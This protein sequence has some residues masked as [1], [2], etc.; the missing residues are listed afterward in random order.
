MKIIL[1]FL[2]IIATTANAQRLTAPDYEIGE[3]IIGLY[4]RQS[5]ADS[6]CIIHRQ[7]LF[8]LNKKDKLPTKGCNGGDFIKYEVNKGMPPPKATGNQYFYI[9][10]S[11]PDNIK[12]LSDSNTDFSVYKSMIL[13]D[14]NKILISNSLKSWKEALLKAPRRN[15]V[16]EYKN[17]EIRYH[18]FSSER[19]ESSMPT[20]FYNLESKLKYS[21]ESSYDF[22][23][24]ESILVFNILFDASGDDIQI[25]QVIISDANEYSELIYKYIDTLL[26]FEYY[27]SKNRAAKQF[28]NSE[29]MYS[30]IDAYHYDNTSYIRIDDHLQR[31]YRLSPKDKKTAI[32][33]WYRGS[34]HVDFNNRLKSIFSDGSSCY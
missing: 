24:S 10:G 8:T 11:C 25:G 17:S 15:G 4:E 34:S 6:I 7:K 16:I 22:E 33:N 18:Y 23:G 30:F 3:N 31:L 29:F 26:V 2:G 12:E 20:I 19:L 1:I 5:K 21:L 27:S 13:S 14:E 28:K 9:E 32:K